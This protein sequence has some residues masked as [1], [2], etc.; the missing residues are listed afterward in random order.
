MNE[1][2]TG[3]YYRISRYSPDNPA[4]C[5][6]FSQRL[7]R[8]NIWTHNYASRVIE[9]YKRFMFLAVA[10]G[11][12]VT[13]SEQVDQVWHLHLVYTREYW[14]DFCGEVL[15]Q[16]VHHGPTKGGRAEAD[17]FRSQYQQT[18]NS[19]QKWFHEVPPPDI[20]PPVEARFAAATESVWVNKATAWIIP[21]PCR[22]RWAS[23]AS[24]LLICAGV[25]PLIFRAPSPFDFSGTDF[26]VFFL[27][28]SAIGLVAAILL[29]HLFRHDEPID[30][31]A[32]LSP[33]EIACLARGVK[34]V[35]ESG[36]AA[37]VIDGRLRMIEDASATCAP[38][39]S[40]RSSYL[41]QSDH[42]AECTDTVESALTQAA[43]LP[44]GVT[45][46]EILDSA[47]SAAEE[48]ESRLRAKGLL[49]SPQSFRPA[50][51]W[52]TLILAVIWL[53]GAAQMF[54][55]LSRSKPTGFL[56]VGL[57][58]LGI[59]LIAFQIRPHRTRAGERLFKRLE[60]QH[61]KLQQ[62][63]C[64]TGESWAKTDLILAAGLFGI[65]AIDHAEMS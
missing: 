3:L 52:P 25:V 15:G 58:S 54:V 55:G 40:E 20:W 9:E 14:D 6:A 60:V 31:R 1:S 43:S 29:R 56:I 64:G 59:L 4:S 47:Q 7:A 33:Y 22:A 12:Q 32:S 61:Q 45:P 62:A 5:L 8:E 41:F 36:L 10:A 48:I 23:R 53:L 17:R 13:P 63:R 65:T 57:V 11:H 44:N 28:T 16:R 35:V 42:S 21:K 34:G 39:S 27:V 24:S 18:L 26:L 19:Y 49:E 51:W 38:L 37:L 30:E 46:A 50:R 2:L